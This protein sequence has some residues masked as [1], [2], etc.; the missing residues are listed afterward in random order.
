MT[1]KPRGRP[2]KRQSETK[3]RLITIRVREEDHKRL[4]AAA[5]IQ[6]TTLSAFVLAAA[7]WWAEP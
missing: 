5:K 6:K 2:P 1:K 4:K 7:M 3:S